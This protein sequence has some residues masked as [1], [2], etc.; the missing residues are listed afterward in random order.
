M[1]YIKI[2]GARQHNLKNINLDIPKNKLVVITGISGSGK[3]SLAFDTIYAEGQRRYVESLSAYARQFLGIMDKPDVD[4][5]EGLSPSISIDQKMASHNPR[6]TVGTITEIYDYLRLLF[7]R[8]GHPHCSH[9]GREISRLTVDEITDRLVL[10]IEK[11]V[12]RDKVIPHKFYVYSPVVRDK[13]GEFKSLF[14]NLKSKGFSQVKVDNNIYNLDQEIDL[15]KTNKHSVYVLV[16]YLSETYKNFKKED[17]RKALGLELKSIVEQCLALSDGLLILN[18]GNKD[19]LYSEKFSCPNCNL[20]IPEIEPRMFSFNSPLGACKKCHGIGTIF[21]VDPE[22]IINKNLSVN[23]GGIL[24]FNKLFFHETWFIRV[25]KTA[26][27]EEGI[28]LEKPLGELNKKQL[29]ILLHGTGKVYQVF[30]KNRFGRQT[31][32]YEKFNGIIDELERRYFENQQGYP[33]IDKYIREVVCPSCH[34]YRLTTEILSITVNGLNIWEISQ[35]SVDKLL[36]YFE[37]EFRLQLNSYEAQISKPIIK[38]MLTRLIFLKNVGLSYLSIDRTA[39][40]L[41]GGELQRIRLASQIGTGLTGV[42][43]VLDEPSIG[44]HARDVNALINTL[45]KLRDLGNS[46]IVVEHDWETIEAADHLIELG[47]KAG[48]N[49]GA[50]VY[51][52]NVNQMKKNSKS[53]TG[54]YLSG[55]RTINFKPRALNKNQ[56]RLI[57]TNIAENNLKKINFD[58][59]LGNLVA[60]TGVSGSGKSSLVVETLYP[61]LRYYLEGYYQKHIGKFDRLE[62]YQYLD[63][64]LLVDQSPIGRTPRSNAATYVGFFDQIRDTFAATIDARSKGFKKGR[65]SFNV[66]GG[67]CEKCQGAGVIKVEMQFLA[68][69]YVTCD[70]CQG[71]RYNQETLGIMFKNKTIYDVLKFTV[72]ETINFFAHDQYIVKKL[73][74][75]QDVGLGYIELGQ[76]APTFSG[77]EAQ[78]IKLAAELSK[79][80]TGR[81]LYILDEPTTGLHFFDIEKLINVLNQLVDMGNTVIIIEHNLDV[82]KNCQYI[83]DLGPEGGEKGGKIMYQGLTE[84]IIKEQKSYTGEYLQKILNNKY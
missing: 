58:I 15:I 13:K 77:G 17:Y 65:F 38:E 50:I 32:I 82:I 80:N 49:G 74:L 78:R 11:E 40:S 33:E 22:L 20:S 21:Q 25:L 53:L 37:K 24:P 61:A 60:V 7:A 56:G 28:N 83:I 66:K 47:P 68:D 36:I 3:S 31:V 67:R 19:S 59:P 1:D 35:F 73:L 29:E 62:G 79:K 75:L 14:E 45:K 42:L 71:K 30:G 52:G 55:R 8:I 64:V 70:V 72:D 84:G 46:V 5:I 69:I 12:G 16:K 48:K 39:R 10:Q 6:S 51:Q 41:A 4:L 34:G 18:S 26:L 63:R 76:G 43:Y 9:C 27:I 2:R 57:L 23:E 44:L 54:S 81:T